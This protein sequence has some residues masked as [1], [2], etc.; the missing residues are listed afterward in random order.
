MVHNNTLKQELCTQKANGGINHISSSK[1]YGP[2]VIPALIAA[3]S[4]V[5]RCNISS[6]RFDCQCHQLFLGMD[7]R[8]WGND[9]RSALPSGLRIKSAMTGR[10]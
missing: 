1:M 7:S 2:A 5:V 4:L 8:F 3:C 6:I 10:R 9:G